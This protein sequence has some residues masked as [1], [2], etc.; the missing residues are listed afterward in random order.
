MLTIP[1]CTFYSI[2]LSGDLGKPHWDIHGGTQTVQDQDILASL[3]RDLW[4]SS[5]GD[6]RKKKE[7]EG[8]VK[9][10]VAKKEKKRG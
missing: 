4:L 2:L 9:L 5:R 3:Q 1:I 6:G 10:Y 8:I 7:W